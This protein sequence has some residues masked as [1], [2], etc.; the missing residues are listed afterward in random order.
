MN[1]GQSMLAVP[2]FCYMAFVAANYYIIKE[3]NVQG[4]ILHINMLMDHADMFV[5]IGLYI[6]IGMMLKQT[7]IGELVFRIFKPWRM[8]PEIMAF[9]AVVLMAV[10]TAY[11]GASGVIIMALGAVVYLELRR[12]GA[13]RQLALAATAMSGSLGVVLR[14]C[15]LVVLIAALNKEVTTNQ[16]FYWGVN[17]FILTALLFFLISLAGKEGPMRVA[18]VSEALKPSLAAFKPLIPYVLVF[19]GMAIVYRL[20]L[21]AKL[22]EFSAPVM[23]PVIIL[24]LLI[25]E[26]I[27]GKPVE[28]PDDHHDDERQTTAEGSIRAATTESTIHIGALLTIMALGAALGGVFEGSHAIL[29][30]MGDGGEDSSIWQTLTVLNITLIL[31]GMT[32]DAFAAVIVVTFAVAQMT[33]AAGVD[34]L[35]FWMIVL[36]AFELSDLTP[37]VAVNHLFT[38]QVVGQEE[39][40]LAVEE[41]RGKSFW[42]RHE[43]YLLPLAVMISALM[44][45]SYGPIIYQKFF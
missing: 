29:G 41:T 18:P 12:A 28:R 8:P 34:P 24:A 21:D 32:M 30:L 3:G 43:R 26:K 10:P 22:D 35:H 2:L 42:R 11:T 17:V 13:R 33:Y 36:V 31:I 16:L 6:W 23:L 19:V 39:I 44:I 45:V 5:K 40:D 37:P 38:R 27:W 20:V 9:V 7:F 1:I 15:L 14:P 4:I 25:Y